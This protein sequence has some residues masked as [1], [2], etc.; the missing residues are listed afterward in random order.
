[1]LNKEQCIYSGISV[2]VRE[3]ENSVFEQNGDFMK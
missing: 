1:M 3:L 2:F